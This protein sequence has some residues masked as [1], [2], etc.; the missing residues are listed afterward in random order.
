MGPPA[1]VSWD[2]PQAVSG[3]ARIRGSCA[4]FFA[5][6]SGP[7]VARSLTMSSNRT[8]KMYFAGIAI[9]AAAFLLSG[10]RATHAH[11]HDTDSQGVASASDR[12]AQPIAEDSLPCRH[13][14]K[15]ACGR[16]E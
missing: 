11:L 7:S 13:L 10:A 9:M 12:P 16:E 3:D 5:A 14:C 2:R 1:G 8:L 6:R 4:A 15:N